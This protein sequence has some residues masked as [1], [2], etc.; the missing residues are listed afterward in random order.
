VTLYG[1][2]KTILMDR[3]IDATRLAI[4]ENGTRPGSYF[5]PNRLKGA[6]S[7]IFAFSMLEKL[8]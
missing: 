1:I 4:A 7:C 6:M 8:K 3:E 5:L 2:A